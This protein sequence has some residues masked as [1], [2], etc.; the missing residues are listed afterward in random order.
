MYAVETAT[1]ALAQVDALPRELLI[2]YAE[3]M[4]LLEID[5]WSGA[6]YDQITRTATSVRN[7]SGLRDL[8][9]SPT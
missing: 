4:A 1:D 2:A 6:P 5:P 8:A 9:S 3:L 7:I